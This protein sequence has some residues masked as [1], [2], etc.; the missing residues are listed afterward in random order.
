MTSE[1]W[2]VYLTQ[3]RKR[4]NSVMKKVIF[5]LLCVL[6]TANG[7]CETEDNVRVGRYG[8]INIGGELKQRDLIDQVVNITFPSQVVSIG[9][10]IRF[11]LKETGYSLASLE[12]SDPQM[13]TLMELNLPG[14]HRATGPVKLSDALNTITTNAWIL[15]VDPYGRLISF[16]LNKNAILPS[17]LVENEK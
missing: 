8:L 16:E 15:V 12:A 17:Y 3:K 10:A 9:D 6:T 7:Y 4:D 13:G 11:L 5:A 14:I 1:C 2:P